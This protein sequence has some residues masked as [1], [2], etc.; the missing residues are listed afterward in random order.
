MEIYE[1][2]FIDF[3]KKEKPY[4]EFFKNKLTLENI[5]SFLKKTE[6]M[7][8]NLKEYNELNEKGSIAFKNKDGFIKKII[9]IKKRK[10]I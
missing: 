7:F 5:N 10:M 8:L 2:K 4:K 1:I 9:S 6:K 3:D